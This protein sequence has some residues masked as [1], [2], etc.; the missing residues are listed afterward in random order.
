MIFM[1][2]GADL[3]VRSDRFDLVDIKRSREFIGRNDRRVSKAALKI[4]DILLAEAGSFSHRRLRQALRPTQAV[5]V[6]AD[7]FVHIMRHMI[8]AYMQLDSSGSTFEL[9]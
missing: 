5:E 9:C 7:Q 3:I 8:A 1:N 4:A 6:A 2:R